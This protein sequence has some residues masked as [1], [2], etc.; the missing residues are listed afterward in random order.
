MT[1]E[2][3]IVFDLEFSA[4]TI[5]LKKKRVYPSRN[6]FADATGNSQ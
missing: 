4:D 2:M 6:N 1:A 5:F 3:I